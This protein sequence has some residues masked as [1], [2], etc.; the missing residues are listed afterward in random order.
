VGD[1]SLDLCP[2]YDKDKYLTAAKLGVNQD[3]F[4]L[5]AATECKIFIGDPGGGAVLPT[6]TKV[7]RLMIN[8]YPYIQAL[9]GYLI[10]FKRLLD[11]KGQDIP[12]KK[13]F[14]QLTYHF[15]PNISSGVRNNTENEILLAVKE[16]TSVKAEIWL[17]Y[18]KGDIDLHG[19]KVGNVLGKN[20]GRLHLGPCRLAACQEESIMVEK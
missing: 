8:G 14:K 12:F 2:K 19:R 3:W 13:S 9:H 20:F 10:L 15:D 1:R 16:L 18:I 6:V 5:F 4:N 11:H 7:P 17:G